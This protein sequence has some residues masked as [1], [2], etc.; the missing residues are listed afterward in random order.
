VQHG[1]LLQAI[2]DTGRGIRFHGAA[3]NIGGGFNR[4][5]LTGWRDDGDENGIGSLFNAGFNV[6]CI[7]GV[8]WVELRGSHIF[9]LLIEG[10]FD[11]CPGF[12]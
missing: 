3:N 8:G 7:V 6:G 4:V 2:V 1:Y 12:R 10:P 11:C 5:N 9:I